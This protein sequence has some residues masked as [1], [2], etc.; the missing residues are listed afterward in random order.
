MDGDGWYYIMILWAI[1][2]ISYRTTLVVMVMD[3]MVGEWDAGV[4][5]NIID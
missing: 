1:T 3:V 2:S 5:R 4:Y